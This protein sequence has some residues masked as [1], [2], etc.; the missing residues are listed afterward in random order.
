MERVV[1]ILHAKVESD[2]QRR[3]LVSGFRR[4]YRLSPCI[5]RLVCTMQNELAMACHGTSKSMHACYRTQQQAAPSK[6]TNGAIV[7]TCLARGQSVIKEP[8]MLTRQRGE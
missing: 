5:G 4:D 1:V 6:P 2:T 7:T 3:V 8:A